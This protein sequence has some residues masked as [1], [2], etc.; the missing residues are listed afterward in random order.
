[1]QSVSRCVIHADEKTGKSYKLLVEG[2]NFK[3]VLATTEINGTK[4]LFN[5]A[6]VVAEV[7]YRV[8]CI[9]NKIIFL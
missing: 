2:T 1:M 7:Y 6:C 4:T 8:F 3:E 9:L 5:N